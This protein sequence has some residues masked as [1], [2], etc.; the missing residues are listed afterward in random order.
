MSDTIFIHIPKTGGTT[1]NSAMNNKAWQGEVGYT[2]RHILPDKTSNSGDIFDN[3]KNDTF[4][5]NSI[6][7]ILRDP[8]DRLISEY[9]FIREREE[10]MILLN[11]RPNNFEEYIRHPQTQNYM[12]GFL[13]GKRMF[14]NEFPNQND[15]QDVIKAIEKLNIYVGIFEEFGVSLTYFNRNAS[16]EFK[17]EIEKKRV[18]FKRPAV[19]EVSE[20]LKQLIREQNH[21]DQELYDFCY[22]RFKKASKGLKSKI[23]FTGDKYDHVIPYAA[24]T[25]LYEM[26]LTNKS[27]IKVNF[28][29]F[30]SMTFFLLKT[31]NINDGRIYVKTWNSAFVSHIEKQFGETDLNK[32]LSEIQF[33]N[34]DPIEAVFKIGDEIESFL[35]SNS[36]KK[37][38]GIKFDP[39]LIPSIPKVERKSFLQKLFNK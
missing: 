24:R 37:I 28:D 16:V 22:S 8:V 34:E 23:K 36:L 1:I 32:K 26:C 20:E 14:D 17:K 2:Y 10:F 25:C 4:L 19:K 13:K 21:L 33:D 30:K 5:N 39:Y 29:F 27:F 3:E 38:S 18:T 7:T 6:I 15:L 9:H 31:Y 35:K 11:P 12:L